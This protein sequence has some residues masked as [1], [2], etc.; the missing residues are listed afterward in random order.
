[1]WLTTPKGVKVPIYALRQWALSPRPLNLFMGVTGLSVGLSYGGVFGDYNHAIH[2]LDY[3][4]SPNCWAVIWCFVGLFHLVITPFKNVW[5]KVNFYVTLSWSVLC[6]VWSTSW[7]IA[8]ATLDD[9]N[10]G[11]SRAVWYLVCPMLV[12][13]V[14]WGQEKYFSKINELTELVQWMGGGPGDQ[15]SG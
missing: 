15:T 7:F 13:W 10:R 4:V 12:S 6:F 11:V 3:L 5:P 8:W 1:M 14:T 2:P 9:V